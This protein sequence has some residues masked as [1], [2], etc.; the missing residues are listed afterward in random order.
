MPLRNK[1]VFDIEEIYYRQLGNDW[2]VVESTVVQSVTSANTVLTLSNFTTE[3]LAESPS[4]QY[5]TREK[6]LTGF[7]A[8][9][10]V[11]IS[12]NG[13]VSSRG[14][15]PGIGIFSSGINL[16][17]YAVPGSTLANAFILTNELANVYL[18]HSLI[19]TNRTASKAYLTLEFLP[20][21]MNSYEIE[22]N[23][24]ICDYLEIPEH[25]SVEIFRKPFIIF[26][27]G[28]I[29]ARSFAANLTPTNNILSLYGSFQTTNDFTFYNLTSKLEY[30]TPVLISSPQARVTISESIVLNN[31]SDIDSAVTIAIKK[32][33][34]IAEELYGYL[35]SNLVIPPNSSVEIAEKPKVI[36]SFYYLEGINYTPNT[37]VTGLF[38]GRF[39]SGYFIR[40]NKEIVAEGDT[41]TFDIETTNV[42]DGTVV[43]YQIDM[44][45]GNIESIDFLEPLSGNLTIQDSTARVTFTANLDYNTDFELEDIFQ[46]TLYGS[47]NLF[48][49]ATSPPVAIQDTSNIANF[50][51]TFFED[52]G[53]VLEG[54]TITL[55]IVHPNL[56][57]GTTLNWYTDG[58]V[59]TD[60]FTE[61][62][63]GVL[64]TTVNT[65]DLVLNSLANCVEI[66]SQELFFRV[67]IEDTNGNA[68]ISSSNITIWD[69]A[70][71]QLTGTGG[72]ILIE[73]TTK[74][75]IFTGSGTFNIIRTAPT[76]V[77]ISYMVQAGG[78]G[79][80]SST[81]TYVSGGGGGAGGH[82]TGTL[83]VPNSFSVPAPYTITVGAGGSQNSNGS[84]SSAL[85][86]TSAGGGKGGGNQQ[87][88]G[89][90]N[91]GGSGGGCQPST[92][93][94]APGNNPPVSPVQGYPSSPNIVQSPFTLGP[95]GAGG[96]GG[97]GG[98]G[99]GPTYPSTPTTSQSAGRRGG[100][101]RLS[102]LSPPAYGTPARYFGGGG[103]G[104]GWHGAPRPQHTPSAPPSGG[105]GTGS[106]SGLLNG[107]SGVANRGGGG[108]GGLDGPAGS[109]G[110][111]IVIISYPIAV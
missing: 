74:K 96:G 76:P 108:G 24:L 14:D 67:H 50:S 34:D 77:T 2:P 92:N 52:P 66:T 100:A 47:S 6:S 91:P 28:I 79:G 42:P 32:Q 48:V 98:A 90:G 26:A 1:G 109:G 40:A 94:V 54:D 64:V 102:P 71:A 82:R 110:K 49:V 45:Q 30:D 33:T 10:G 31:L 81:P 93:F 58:N 72:T 95:L 21:G 107:A 7:T 84:P 4:N 17:Q 62:N 44:V 75:H 111:G 86:T 5:F 80:G 106:W 88:G 35:A 105:G 41:V 12:A 65:T 11:D 37:L 101:G 87:T 59:T 103:G 13:I 20:Q 69:T 36:D 57:E 38:S 25:G 3:D 23:V 43:Y 60:T 16:R 97:A 104:A 27:D 51:E 63:S 70:L 22:D 19:A 18:I 29:R 55:T 8:G 83:V 73:G 53:P 39:S 61:G 78:G 56:P 15:S 46:L 68:M 89:R 9:A 99:A 85:G